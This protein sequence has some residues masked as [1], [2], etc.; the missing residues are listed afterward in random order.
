MR[1]IVEIVLRSDL[2]AATGSHYASAIDLDTAL[3]EFGLPYIPSRRLKGCLRE[4]ASDVL[5]V[6]YQEIDRIFGVSGS[7]VAGSFRLTDAKL[8]DY[9]A[10]A[11]V[12]EHIIEHGD[13]TSGEISDLFCSVRSC[14][15]MENGSAKDGSLRFVRVVNRVSPFDNSPMTFIATV[16]Y[17]PKDEDLI[18]KLF[19]CL[20]NIGYHRNRGLGWIKCSLLDYT[21]TIHNEYPEFDDSQKYRIEYLIRLDGDLMMPAESADFSRD[22]IPGTSV[23]GALAGKYQAKFGDSGFDDLFFSTSIRF[24]NAYISDADGNN[25]FPVPALFGKSKKADENNQNVFNL[26][27]EKGRQSEQSE[28]KLLKP[29]KKGYMTVDS[30]NRLRFLNPKGSIVYHNSIN[31]SEKGLYAQY[32]IHAGQFFKGFIEADGT[33]ASKIYS[34]LSA[35]DLSFGRSKTAQYSN[36][37]IH[38][39][40]VSESIEKDVI[41]IPG[42]KAAYLC[43][44]DIVIC[45]NGRYSVDLEDI[46]RELNID[47]DKVD[48]STSLF[49][50]VI[51]GYNSKSNM[52]KSQF[53]VIKAGSAIVFDVSDRKCLKEYIS[54]GARRNEG[55]GQ[56]RLIPDATFFG[57]G[58]LVDK[59]P[60]SSDCSN[61]QL[62]TLVDERKKEKD[63]LNAAIDCFSKLKLNSSQ[64]GRLALMC[65]ESV[66]YNDFLKRVRSIKTESV[67]TD[68]LVFF[69][70]KKIQEITGLDPE[71]A[72]N[73][74]LVKLF[75][76]TVLTLKKYEIKAEG[77]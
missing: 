75:I 51:S 46:C 55:Y 74:R 32:C 73:W 7:S 3:D 21:E 63:C 36:C 9:T 66:D 20:R 44:S 29:I 54:I 50:R 69:N 59:K 31:V 11:K 24:G 14:T 39:I 47:A 8:R 26:V 41:T 13:S 5:C 60:D 33:A 40:H 35:G 58:G 17:D 4:I 6:H 70:S 77:N 65:R 1:K 62:L 43:E 64:T 71:Q 42:K 12:A 10:I 27:F 16:D 34:L 28:V 72:R 19:K 49:S 38:N 57:T 68:S 52:K 23:L 53:P 56:V 48:P 18:G 61:S 22:Y 67:K 2:C 30:G 45:N 15:A 37:S 76:I 25:Y